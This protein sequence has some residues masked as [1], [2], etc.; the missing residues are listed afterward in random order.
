ML[1]PI[2]LLNKCDVLSNGCD[3]DCGLVCELVCVAQAIF[4]DCHYPMIYVDINCCNCGECV[5]ACPYGACKIL[6]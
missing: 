1:D 6:D 5:S 2:T 4:I 3:T